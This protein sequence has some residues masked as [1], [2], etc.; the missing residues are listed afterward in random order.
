[1]KLNNVIGLVVIL[2]V[3]LLAGRVHSQEIN[4]LSGPLKPNSIQGINSEDIVLPEF[5]TY[6]RI[7]KLKKGLNKAQVFE[8]LEVYPYKIIYNEKSE[9]EVNIF[10]CATGFRS[11]LLSEK[12]ENGTLSQLNMGELVF[13]SVLYEIILFYKKGK[14]E[15][16]INKDREEDA[17][18]LLVL[19]NSI[20]INCSD[21]KQKKVQWLP[22]VVVGCRDTSALNFDP[23]ATL[24]YEGSCKY[25]RCGYVKLHLSK[26]ERKGCT[27]DEVPGED[28]WNFWLSD[29]RCGEIREAI[30]QYPPLS[31]RLPKDFFSMCTENKLQNKTGEC[32][33]CDVMKSKDFNK[34]SQ[35]QFNWSK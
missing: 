17:Y 33:W 29:G 7:M 30:S 1:M 31:R 19:G 28:L 24:Q 21:Y 23:N 22:R 2:I 10:K 25:P 27:V 12:P 6:D 26:N 34:P 13:S 18:K 4:D 3:I 20:D 5:T 8:I 9:C 15:L 32:D 11:N 16:F 35:I 14:L